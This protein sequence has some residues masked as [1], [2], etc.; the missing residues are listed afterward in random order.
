MVELA[1][2]GMHRLA[3]P[4]VCAVPSMWWAMAKASPTSSD[5]LG[6]RESSISQSKKAILSR[7]KQQMI[8]TYPK[9]LENGL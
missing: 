9:V 3:K 1:G 6:G 4:S 2:C 7:Q 8:T 5:K